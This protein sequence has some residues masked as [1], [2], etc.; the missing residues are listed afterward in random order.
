MKAAVYLRVSTDRQEEANQEPDCLRICQ[1]R[2]WDPVIFREV[3]SGAKRRPK[4]DEVK[5]AAHRGE[6]G[7][8][9][10]WALDRAGRD[11]V[12]LAGDLAE[13]AHK[14]VQVA[15]VR[16]S[17][18]D[19][20]AGPLRDLLV[21]IFAW[22]AEAERTRLVERTKAG[23]ARAVAMGK[24]LGR[25]PVPDAKL[26]L[27]RELCAQ[28]VGTREAGRRAGV[29]E[30]TARTWFARFREEGLREKGSEKPASESGQKQG[31]SDHGKDE[32]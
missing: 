7:A 14:Q 22:F 18:V 17:W 16:E 12:R 1:A 24:R 31:E 13:L 27:L 8:V 29:A 19:Q 2:G 10:V 28:G 20:P 25:K 4:W 9:V 26:G 30:S 15:S 6:V 21:Q 23:I 32:R 5:R 11:R 3:E